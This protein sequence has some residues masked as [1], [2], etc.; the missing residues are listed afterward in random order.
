M[1]L[2]HAKAKVIVKQME[3]VNVT[4]IIMEMIVIVMPL[5]HAR[6]KGIA[7]LM[8]HVNAMPIIMELIVQVCHYS[9]SFDIT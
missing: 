5:Q 6:V 9:F 7:K 3:P 4:P 2:Q 8:E 1:P